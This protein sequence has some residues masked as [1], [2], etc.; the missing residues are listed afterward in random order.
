MEIMKNEK[1]RLLNKEENKKIN[2]KDFVIFYSK[3][4]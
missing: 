4:L 2:M 3:M 1:N